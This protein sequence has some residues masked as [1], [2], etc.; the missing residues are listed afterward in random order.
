M[1]LQFKAALMS[2]S[3]LARELLQT[4]PIYKEVNSLYGKHK[5]NVQKDKSH[6]SNT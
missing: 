3:E 2:K 4:N 1:F 6:S 5:H